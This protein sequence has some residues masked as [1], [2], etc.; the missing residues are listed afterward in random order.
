M[1]HARKYSDDTAPRPHR[2]HRAMAA[3]GRATSTK[4]Q[5]QPPV[6]IAACVGGDTREWSRFMEV[7]GRVIR[8]AVRWTLAHRWPSGY[9]EADVDDVVQNVLFRLVRSA[10]RLLSTYDPERSS[11]STWLCV[12]AR[13]AAI[14]HIRNKAS[15]IHV[16]LD[17]CGELVAEEA[18]LEESLTLPG[19]VLSPRQRQVVDMTVSWDMNTESIARAM[20]IHPQTV[21]SLR[22]N[23]VAKLRHYYAANH[24]RQAG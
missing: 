9:A 13:S 24:L 16:A 5:D 20:D 14:D 11:L 22:H 15:A 6:D 1:Q 21:R 18:E 17:D 7:Y 8:D 4:P 2:A 19:H 23:A 10:Y 3:S 12:V